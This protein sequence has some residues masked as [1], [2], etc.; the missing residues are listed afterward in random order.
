MLDNEIHELLVA[1]IC[2]FTT[3][4]WIQMKY[5][6]HQITVDKTGKMISKALSHARK[7]Y[8]YKKFEWPT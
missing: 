3:N 7:K 1:Y 8:E 4:E 6:G 2:D 5:D